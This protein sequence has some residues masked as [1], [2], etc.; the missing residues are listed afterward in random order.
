MSTFTQ[1]PVSAIA[2][3]DRTVYVA[4]VNLKCSECEI[5]FYFQEDYV[6]HMFHVSLVVRLLNPQPISECSMWSGSELSEAHCQR[7]IANRMHSNSMHSYG[8]IK[9]GCCIH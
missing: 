5:L 3:L 4:G 2:P 8:D 1:S 7:L 6:N 9:D